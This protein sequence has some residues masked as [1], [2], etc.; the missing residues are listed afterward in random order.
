MVQQ[1]AGKYKLKS[2]ENLDAFLKKLNMGV[3]KRKIAVALKPE[4]EILAKDNG[5]TWISKTTVTSTNMT[6]V[7]GEKIADKDPMGED[8]E[9]VWEMSGEK[10]IGVFTYPN[11]NKIEIERVVE[12][13]G[14]KQTMVYE[15]VTAVR[16][17]EKLN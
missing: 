11:G 3:I 1:F 4:A 17:F 10:M 9:Q 6:Y 13:N 7:F 8:G 15:G 5:F 12:G 14:F 16:F 2:Q